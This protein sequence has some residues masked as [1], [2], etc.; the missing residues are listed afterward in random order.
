[1]RPSAQPQTLRAGLFTLSIT[2]VHPETI[3]GTSGADSLTGG[4]DI[5]HIFGLGGN[6]TLTG[7]TS[8]DIL[9]GGKGR[10]TMT[11]GAGFDDFDFNA[12]TETGKTAAKRDR[13]LDFKHLQDDIDLRT[14]DAKTGIAG[15][16]AFKFIGTQDFHDV[17][18]ELRLF[19]QQCD[20]HRQ[21]QDD[22]RGRRQW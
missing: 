16:Q 12:I 13:I 14:I 22:R 20:R 18:G 11:G 15:N 2:D 21:R 8:A 19:Q 9:T 3:T 4:S 7:G 1:M 5:D 10:D 17:K 6:D